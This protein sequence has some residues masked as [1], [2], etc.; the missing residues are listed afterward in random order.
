MTLSPEF[1]DPIIEERVARILAETGEWFEL[2]ILPEILGDTVE[3][4]LSWF[5]P[6]KKPDLAGWRRILAGNR[7]GGY[8]LKVQPRDIPVKKHGGFLVGGTPGI[9][10]VRLLDSRALD[11]NLKGMLRSDRNPALRYID[12]GPQSVGP[13]TEDPI[14]LNVTYNA[15][16]AIIRPGLQRVINAQSPQVQET[17]PYHAVVELYISEMYRFPIPGE[18]PEV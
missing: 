7:V 18:K 10:L 3:K 11:K 14:A 2:A 5:D 13:L 8:E 9:D 15:R 12:L 6:S 4:V 16:K 1:K 17:E